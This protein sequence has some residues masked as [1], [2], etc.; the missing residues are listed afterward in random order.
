[1]NENG[2]ISFKKPWAFSVPE[3]FPTSNVNNRN[4]FAVAVFWS[5]NDIRRDGAVRY[6]TYS[7][8]DEDNAQGASLMNSMNEF[9]QQNLGEGAEPFLGQWL[10][11]VHWDHVHPSPHGGDSGSGISED[12]LNMVCALFP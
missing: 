12:I 9:V 2:V 5:D 3:N 8:N 7:V 6:V 4:N 10:L 11:A 1:M